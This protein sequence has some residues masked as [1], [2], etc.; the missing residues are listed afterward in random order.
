VHVS[1]S[2]FRLP[3]P[4]YRGERNDLASTTRLKWIGV[5]AFGLVFAVGALVSVAWG[6]VRIVSQLIRAF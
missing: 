3:L 4:R 2:N 5:L 6:V 1:F